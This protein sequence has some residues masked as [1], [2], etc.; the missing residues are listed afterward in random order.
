KLLG[1]RRKRNGDKPE[2]PESPYSSDGKKVKVPPRE[3]DSDEPLPSKK[4]KD[5]KAK[6]G[7]K[8]D[9]DKKDEAKE[10]EEPLYM[11]ALGGHK[12]K[13]DPRFA[14]K[15]RP[16]KPKSKDGKDDAD[17]KQQSKDADEKQMKERE[18]RENDLQAAHDSLGSDQQTL[19][20]M[21]QQLAK[22]T[23]SKG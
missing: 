17:E 20:Q 12:E 15:R 7:D 19:E 8:S 23:Q 6:P 2:F 9:K 5:G 13:M 1:D 16:V 10:D 3:E 14:K 11:P 21:L 18:D 4:D 22:A